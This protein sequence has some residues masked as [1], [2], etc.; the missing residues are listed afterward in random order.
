MTG[1]WE[2]GIPIK[3]GNQVIKSSVYR[4]AAEAIISVANWTD[5]DQVVSL[6]VDWSK[7]GMIKAKTDISIPEIKDFQTG[8]K[9]VSLEK[10]TIAG[11]KGFLIVLKKRDK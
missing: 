10:I 6:D 7:M 8:Q 4:S 11:K 1:Y 2:T 5:L 3:T 9:S